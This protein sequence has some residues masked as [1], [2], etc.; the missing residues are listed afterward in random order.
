MH[1]KNRKIIV[2]TLRES[3]YQLDRNSNLYNWGKFV[4]T[5]DTSIFCP[6][7]IRDTEKVFE[8]LPIGFENAIIFPEVCFNVELRS[9]LNELCYLNMAVDCGTGVLCILNKK[10]KYISFKWGLTPDVKTHMKFL[11][12]EPGTQPSICNPFQKWVWEDD[13]F[14]AINREFNEMVEKIADNEKIGIDVEMN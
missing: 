9:A 6:V 12:I 11:N 3:S 7:I 14:E 1:A 4:K 5:L 10:T 8:S 13:T 2:I